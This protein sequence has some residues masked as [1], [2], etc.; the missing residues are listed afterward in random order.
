M[1]RQCSITLATTIESTAKDTAI[2]QKSR[3]FLHKVVFDN[4]IVLHYFL[5]EHGGVCLCHSKYLL[6]YVGHHLWYYSKYRKLTNKPQWSDAPSGTSFDVLVWFMR[7]AKSLGIILLTGIIIVLLE[8][9][10]LT[11]ISNACSS[12]V[13]QMVSVILEKEKQDE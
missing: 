12:T 7:L 3:E 6:L 5:V 11:E 13:H 10:V 8:R 9:S 2:R 4:G 1:R